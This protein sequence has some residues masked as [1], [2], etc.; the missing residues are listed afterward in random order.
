MPNLEN[1]LTYEHWQYELV[2]HLFTLTVACF[3]AGFVYFV[4]SMRNTAPWY[5]IS[6]VLSAVV[7]V[8]ATYEIFQLFTSWQSSFESVPTSPAGASVLPGIEAG[9]INAYVPVADT[10]FSNGY[11][12]INW[13]IDVPMLLTQLLVVVGLTGAAFWSNWWKL[14]LAGLVM[15]YTGYIGQFWEPQVAGLTEGRNSYPFWVWGFVSTL[16]FIYIN[17]KVMTLTHNMVG[18]VPDRARKEMGRIGIFLVATW[19]LYTIGYVLPAIWPTNDGMVFRQFIYTTA[20]I[21]SKLVFGIMLSRVALIRS[22]YDG[23]E[24]AIKARQGIVFGRPSV[25]VRPHFGTTAPR[26]TIR[27]SESDAR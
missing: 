11:R 15:V 17:Y 14:T 12:Y 6:S 16:P 18:E 24:P 7:M 9:G 22:A 10:M 3:A 25:D 5:R 26:D 20:D 2:R 1:F 21:T 13:S 8:S 27:Q 19:T 4:L 23:F